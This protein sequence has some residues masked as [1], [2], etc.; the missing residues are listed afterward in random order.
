MTPIYESAHIATWKNV[1]RYDS[2]RVIEIFKLCKQ[3]RHSAFVTALP[4]P[5]CNIKEI[6]TATAAHEKAEKMIEVDRKKNEQRHSR[7][8]V[9]EQIAS[10]CRNRFMIKNTNTGRAYL[11]PEEFKPDRTYTN[12]YGL[13]D[14]KIGATLKHQIA[15]ECNSIGLDQ[16]V[17]EA[18]T[19]WNV[20]SII[21]Q[22]EGQENA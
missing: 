15:S 16:F 3:S 10:N 17:F 12:A 7:Q 14:L 13:K 4:K 2:N 20:H 18:V 22:Y 5:I 6:E 19:R 8:I 21:D 1:K 9:R 11:L